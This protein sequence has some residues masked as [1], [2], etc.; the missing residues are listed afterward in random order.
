MIERES[1]QTPVSNYEFVAYWGKSE[2]YLFT[3]EC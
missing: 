1:G 2:D 3:L